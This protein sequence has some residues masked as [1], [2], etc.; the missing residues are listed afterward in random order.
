[1]PKL[2]IPF[3]NDFRGILGLVKQFK[4]KIAE[5]YFPLPKEVCGSGRIIDTQHTYYNDLM[6]SFV[7]NLHDLGVKANLVV[8][9]LSSWHIYESEKKVKL[10]YDTID[11]YIMDIQIDILTTTNPVIAQEF[12]RDVAVH[13]STNLFVNTIHKAQYLK[14]LKFR[15]ICIDRDKNRDVEFI[16]AVKQLGLETKVLVNEG[17]IPFCMSRIT[18]FDALSPGYSTQPSSSYHEKILNTS[19]R[20]LYIKHPELLIKTPI[21]R[22]EDLSYYDMVDVVKIS[23][24]TLPTNIIEKMV[25]AYATG[26]WNGYLEDTVDNPVYQQSTAELK[27][28]INNKLFPSEFGKVTS[29]CDF[30]CQQNRCSLCEKTLELVSSGKRVS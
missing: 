27:I 3:N 16:K 17:C 11:Y 4:D 24:R 2:A 30:K 9:N 7:R 14:D 6:K 15:G 10:L 23:G 26:S 13:G 20:F 5:V 19:C 12:H 25:R 1:M 29:S 28:R 18:H 8:N 22:P 21:I